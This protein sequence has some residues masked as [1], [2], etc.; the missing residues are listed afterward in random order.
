MH[1]FA[2]IGLVLV[3]ACLAA[4]CG[5]LEGRGFGGVALRPIEIPTSA[6]RPDGDQTVF[7][8]LRNDEHCFYAVTMEGN[9]PGD[10]LLPIWPAGFSAKV[11]P[12]TRLLFAGPGQEADA[13]VAGSERME[14]HGQYVD[15]PPADTLIPPGCSGTRL[16]HVK[17]AFNRAP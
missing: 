13:F 9:T 15:A 16:F 8:E 17:Q 14:L 3:G 10:N 6:F 12:T 11:G 4:A 7:A 2:I 1:R 5:L